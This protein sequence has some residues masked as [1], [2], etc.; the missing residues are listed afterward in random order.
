MKFK[1]SYSN[2][3]GQIVNKKMAVMVIVATMDRTRC[4]IHNAFGFGVRACVCVCVVYV[5]KRC[6][7]NKNK[8]VTKTDESM[9]TGW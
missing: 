6:K 7:M 8:D 4:T 3:P 1:K 5:K 2:R 9:E